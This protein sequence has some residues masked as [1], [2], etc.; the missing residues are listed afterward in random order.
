MV[1]IREPFLTNSFQFFSLSK[2]D[3]PTYTY[4][5]IDHFEGIVPNNSYDIRIFD[6]ISVL[7]VIM[8]KRTF[9][10]NN[11]KYCQDQLAKSIKLSVF[12]NSEFENFEVEKRPTN[13]KRP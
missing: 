8:L 10:T 5:F 1:A 2:L 3:L 11:D 7:S 13:G 4:I 12:F 9:L 6:L